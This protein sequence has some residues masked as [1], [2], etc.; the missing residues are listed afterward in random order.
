MSL[1]DD[2]ILLGS[3]FCAT[4]EVAE[5]KNR[6]NDTDIVGVEMIGV[7]I[8][9]AKSQDRKNKTKAIKQKQ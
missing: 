6:D 8:T 7:R 3:N 4:S 2:I 5:N 1:R 9:R